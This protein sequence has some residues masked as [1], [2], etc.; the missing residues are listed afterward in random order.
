MLFWCRTLIT[1]CTLLD[2]PARVIDIAWQS[3]YKFAITYAAKEPDSL[4]NLFS[5]HLPE[6]G[7]TRQP[8]WRSFEDPTFSVSATRKAQLYLPLIVPWNTFAVL[9][10]NSGDC[11][12]MGKQPAGKEHQIWTFCDEARAELP[13]LEDDAEQVQNNDFGGD[14][15]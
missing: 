13:L 1:A 6:K 7:E 2:G 5:V 4:P 9:S 10:S 15:F 11:A 8:L 12:L 14:C 3:T